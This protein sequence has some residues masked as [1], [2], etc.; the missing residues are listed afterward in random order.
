MVY[1]VIHGG[2]RDR[3][4]AEEYQYSYNLNHTLSCHVLLFSRC[5]LASPKD[6]FLENPVQLLSE[7]FVALQVVAVLY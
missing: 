5:G 2:D 7:L 6:S 3:Y 4:N 1:L